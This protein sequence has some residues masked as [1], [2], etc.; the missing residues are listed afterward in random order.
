MPP[1]HAAVW[2]R[3]EEQGRASVRPIPHPTRASI[4]RRPLT[5]EGERLARATMK[6]IYF[7]VP[8]V[9]IAKTIVDE[10]LLARIEERHITFWPST[11]RRWRT[12]PKPRCCKERFHPR[13]GARLGGRRHGRHSW[14]A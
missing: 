5:T 6:R 9:E 12:C 4:A 7:L 2:D 8:T 1:A 10:L 3:W 14:P 13:D 11:A